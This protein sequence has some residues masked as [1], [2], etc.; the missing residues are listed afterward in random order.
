[1][2]GCPLPRFI[3]SD[4]ALFRLHP[5]S[6]CSKY[7]LAV[8]RVFSGVG[9]STWKALFRVGLRVCRRV[10][11]KPDPL[12]PGNVGDNAN[13]DCGLLLG[14]LFMVLL[15]FSIDSTGEVVVERA[16]C[17]VWAI[18]IYEGNDQREI[19]SGTRIYDSR[20]YLA[21]MGISVVDM[22]GIGEPQMN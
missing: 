11:I 21:K 20:I 7:H 9:I 22:D 6:S 10:S 16:R 8:D 3:F 4:S 18:Q 5:V 12:S 2:A 13:F 15:D 14:I 19:Y 17:R 1:M